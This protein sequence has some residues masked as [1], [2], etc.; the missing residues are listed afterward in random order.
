MAEIVDRRYLL[1]KKYL[2]LKK[3]HGHD[4]AVNNMTQ[5]EKDTMFNYIVSC[6][7][8]DRMDIETGAVK[9]TPNLNE[10]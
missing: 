10:V 4:Y 9:I 1:V 5:Q 2:R 6:H 7:T 3:T 8:P